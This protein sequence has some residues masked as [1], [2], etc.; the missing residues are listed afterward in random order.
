MRKIWIE[1]KID[2]SSVLKFGKYQGKIFLEVV[3]KDFKY[4]SF[5]VKNKLIKLTDRSYTLILHL[6]IKRIRIKKINEY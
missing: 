4:V 2:I 6:K 1:P 3:N 5:L